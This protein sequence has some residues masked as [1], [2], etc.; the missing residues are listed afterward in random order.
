MKGVL[1]ES[2]IT[3]VV[4]DYCFLSEE[5]QGGTAAQEG[6]EPSTSVIVLA[7]VETMCMSVW[8]YAVESKGGTEAW[9]AD[10]V[11]EDLQTIGVADEKIILK[12]DQENSIVDLAKEIAKSRPSLNTAI[13][14]SKVGDSNSNG[15]VERAIQ[16]LKVLIRTLRSALEEKTQQKIKLSNAIVP[17]M[18]RHAGH[19]ISKCRIR[20][21]GRTSH[22]ILKGRRSNAKMVL[23][24]RLCYSRFRRVST[25]STASRTAGSRASGWAS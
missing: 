10:Q 4:L 2:D 5:V 22:Q 6:P 14:H 18:V 8:G 24:G 15:K 16:D 13:E 9:V 19:L 3:R 25:R 23:S 20:S 21:N 7:M 12:T 11:A 17:W 1:G